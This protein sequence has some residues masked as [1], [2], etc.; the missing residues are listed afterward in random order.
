MSLNFFE[1]V[2]GKI[3]VSGGDINQ[4]SPLVFAYLGDAVYEVFVRS[5]VVTQGNAPVHV[6]HKRSV[7]LVKAKAQSETIHRILEKLT[8]EEQDI[9][10]RGRNAKSATVPKNADV[11]EYRYATGFEALLGY[12][13]LKGDY[14]RLSWVLNMTTEKVDP[15]DQLVDS[16][17]MK[18]KGD[19]HEGTI[20]E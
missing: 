12:L 11:T 7:S 4:Y 13:Y 14:D 20:S 19:S 9:V 17:S 2:S 18:E 10:R 8:P 5:L 6:M 15:A 3:N 16:Q 1:A